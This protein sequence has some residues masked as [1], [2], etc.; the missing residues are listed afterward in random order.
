M[1]K[2]IFQQ[3]IAGICTLTLMGGFLYYTVIDNKIWV[4]NIFIF[5]TYSVL[6]LRLAVLILPINN[7]KKIEYLK[8]YQNGGHFPKW[9]DNIIYPIIFFTL[10]SQAY[11]FTGIA[12]TLNMV[13]DSIARDES[14]NYFNNQKEETH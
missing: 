6:L 1:N 3:I 9:F 10:I 4:Q 14:D 13:F 2:N 8:T 12:W 11:W 7:P 5:Y